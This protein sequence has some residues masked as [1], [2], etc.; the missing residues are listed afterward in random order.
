MMNQLTNFIVGT[1]QDKILA[2][3]RVMAWRDGRRAVAVLSTCRVL[4]CSQAWLGP[5]ALSRYGGPAS[6]NQA[7]TSEI[8]V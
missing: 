4:Q 1:R 3:M 7:K 5:D 8:A 2:R 6:R